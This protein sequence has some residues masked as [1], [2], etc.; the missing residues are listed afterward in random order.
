MD[1]YE[2]EYHFLDELKEPTRRCSNLVV[3]DS[4]DEIGSKLASALNSEDFDEVD[5]ILSE[6]FGIKD[7]DVCFYY[8]WT[9]LPPQDGRNA[10]SLILELQQDQDIMIYDLTYIEGVKDD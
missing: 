1:L 3:Y 7:D 8:D 4:E 5:D 10:A 2:I 9:S 6:H